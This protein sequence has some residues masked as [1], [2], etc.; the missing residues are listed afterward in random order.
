MRTQPN[1]FKKSVIWKRIEKL[2]HPYTILLF[3]RIDQL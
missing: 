2:N 3:D 1:Y